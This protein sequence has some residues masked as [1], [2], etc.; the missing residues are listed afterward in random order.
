MAV[1]AQGQADAEA[2]STGRAKARVDAHARVWDQ[3][4]H[5]NGGRTHGQ[6]QARRIQEIRDRAQAKAGAVAQVQGG[7][8]HGMPLARAQVKQADGE[9]SWLEARARV[10]QMK[11]AEVERFLR[12]IQRY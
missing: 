10:A 4:A 12:R 11:N 8:R 9:L 7:L 6:V 1:L 5:S 2:Q 3:V